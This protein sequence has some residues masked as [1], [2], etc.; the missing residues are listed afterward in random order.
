VLRIQK[1][2]CRS[3]AKTKIIPEFSA[4]DLRCINPEAIVVRVNVA[5]TEA[6]HPFDAA[7]HAHLSGDAIPTLLSQAPRLGS[8]TC[9]TVDAELH[10]WWS[11]RLADPT[12]GG[13]DWRSANLPLRGAR[14]WFGGAG[15]ACSLSGAGVGT[16]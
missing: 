15:L 12:D 1:L 8:A 14:A 2:A 5:R 3:E 11:K 16:R 6:G 10:A 9:A 13:S 7:Y 4:M